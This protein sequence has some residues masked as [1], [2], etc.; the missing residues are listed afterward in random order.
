MPFWTHTGLGET[1]EPFSN[2]ALALLKFALLLSPTNP[3]AREAS[4]EE[5]NLTVRKNLL[6]HRIWCQR[7]CKSVRPSVTNFA[8]LS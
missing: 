5:A 4:R 6:T 2:V 1:S 7:I 8:Q 3:P